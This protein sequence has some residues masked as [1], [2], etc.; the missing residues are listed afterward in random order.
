MKKLYVIFICTIVFAVILFLP[1]LAK[2]KSIIEPPM[3]DENTLRAEPLINENSPS[4]HAGRGFLA[5]ING[6]YKSAIKHFSKAIELN[7]Q[8]AISYH[9]RG[10]CYY[11][12]NDYEKAMKDFNKTLDLDPSNID[13]Y[14][15][16][17]LLKMDLGD[18]NGAIKDIDEVLKVAPDDP[19]TIKQKELILSKMQHK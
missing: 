8:D 14:W 19:K 13:A 1:A 15:N 9:Q 17:S 6:D 12:E 18:Y 7:P 16:R 5:E 3:P 10:L 11:H 2:K 4:L